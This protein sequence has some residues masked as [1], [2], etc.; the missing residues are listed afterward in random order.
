MKNYVATGG[1]CCIR[2]CLCVRDDNHS[3][4]NQLRQSVQKLSYNWNTM[5]TICNVGP[6]QITVA[7]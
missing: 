5:C 3:E 1:L 7:Y 6:P 2:D 4:N